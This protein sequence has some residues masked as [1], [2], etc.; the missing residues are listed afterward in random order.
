MDSVI[1]SIRII[2]ITNLYLPYVLIARCGSLVYSEFKHTLLHTRLYTCKSLV[3]YHF[4]LNASSTEFLGASEQL[5]KRILFYLDEDSPNIS[6][7]LFQGKPF[8]NIFRRPIIALYGKQ[9]S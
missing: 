6:P 9:Q 5:Y 3:R 1:A 2:A 4:E 8:A 7:P